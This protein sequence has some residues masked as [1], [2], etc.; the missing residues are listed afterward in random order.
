M[1]D[2]AAAAAAHVCCWD[3]LVL[4]VAP[5]CEKMWQ[6]NHKIQEFQGVRKSPPFLLL[7]KKV[8]FRGSLLGVRCKG[9]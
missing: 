2:A 8:R 7:Y 1:R 3:R 4:E 5:T 6:V 9:P